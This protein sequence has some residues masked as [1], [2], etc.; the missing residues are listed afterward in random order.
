MADVHPFNISKAKKDHKQHFTYWFM[1]TVVVAVILY[2]IVV[3]LEWMK[4]VYWKMVALVGASGFI[5]GVGKEI[6]D[7][8]KT[9][10]TGFSWADLSYDMYATFI[11]TFSFAFLLLI[12]HITPNLKKSK[13]RI[14][15]YIIGQ[16]GYI[17]ELDQYNEQPRR[18]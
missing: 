12:I 5:L 1:F 14:Y 2:I 11:V 17:S 4:I 18:L 9:N 16:Q 7:C 6:Y 10:P 8:F 3:I 13:V 15:N